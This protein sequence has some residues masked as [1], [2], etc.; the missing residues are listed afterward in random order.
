MPTR[1]WAE[2]H[3][4]AEFRHFA[5]LFIL[6]L[7]LFLTF[8]S[9]PSS[10][11]ELLWATVIT[12]CPSLEEHRQNILNQFYADQ[13]MLF[14]GWKSYSGEGGRCCL[15][16]LSFLSLMHVQYNSGKSTVYMSTVQTSIFYHDLVTSNAEGISNQES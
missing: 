11:R 5:V 10:A 15:L 2:G 4:F 8:I 6:L 14:L 12:I 3:L 16:L 1:V 7:L 9:H 13:S